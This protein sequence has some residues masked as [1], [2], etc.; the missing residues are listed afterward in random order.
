MAKM[1]VRA[2]LAKKC[3]QA[4]LHMRLSLKYIGE[5]MATLRLEH[6][7]KER[8]ILDIM[9]TIDVA[10]YNLDVFTKGT[11]H[12]ATWKPYTRRTLANMIRRIKPIPLYEQNRR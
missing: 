1:N 9:R 10:R 4:D 12:K 8:A 11:F 5:M 6:P 7:E 3:R 2:R